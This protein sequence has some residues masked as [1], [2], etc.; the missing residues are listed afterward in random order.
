MFAQLNLLGNL[1]LTK[2]MLKTIW[3]KTLLGLDC[4]LG[5]WECVSDYFLKYF[6]TRKYIKLKLFYFK[7]IIFYINISKRFKNIKKNKNKIYT[8]SFETQ[9]KAKA[10]VCLR[11]W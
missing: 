9:Y 4:G 2:S 11:F 10:R 3:N 1:N 8:A 5:V 7:K 6:F